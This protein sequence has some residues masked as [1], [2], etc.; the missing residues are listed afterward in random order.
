MAMRHL[1]TC[2]RQ[3]AKTG[4]VSGQEKSF[5]RRRVR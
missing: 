1:G 3:T 5:T 4:H 2:M